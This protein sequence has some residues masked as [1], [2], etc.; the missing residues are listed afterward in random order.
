MAVE[1]S[2]NI[3]QTCA[4]FSVITVKGIKPATAYIRDLSDSLNSV[5]VLLHFG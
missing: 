4:E 3:K 5:K 2:D 1:K